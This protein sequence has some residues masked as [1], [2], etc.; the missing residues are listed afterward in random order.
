MTNEIEKY[1]E[2]RQLTQTQLATMCG[3]TASTISR[4]ENGE[5]KLSQEY[6]ERLS[7]VL[8]CTPCQLLG[9]S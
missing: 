4:L 1:R 9:W 3:T 6:I 7:R 2:L 5:R 8:I